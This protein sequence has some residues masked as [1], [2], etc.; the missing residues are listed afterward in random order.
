MSG[1]GVLGT[2]IFRALKDTPI[3]I[4]PA[5]A[6]LVSP[7]FT[8]VDGRLIA[9]KINQVEAVI[10]DT[11]IG[12]S[13]VAE[14]GNSIVED[15]PP[16]TAAASVSLSTAGQQNPAVS[17]ASV[18]EVQAPVLTE[19]HRSIP[20]NKM[21]LVAGLFFVGGLLLLTVSVGMYSKMRVGFSLAG[22]RHL[23]RM[24]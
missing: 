22:D 3:T 7:E 20:S 4:I 14:T 23:E 10:S 24:L 11:V 21:L 19:E 1:D 8:Q 9:Q 17:S 15:T 16:D 12:G 2:I 18:G 5:S 6:E 13:L